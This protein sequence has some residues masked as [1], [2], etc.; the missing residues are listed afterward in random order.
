MKE[1]KVIQ[2]KKEKPK[3]QDFKKDK[4]LPRKKSEFVQVKKKQEEEFLASFRFLK[5]LHEIT[6]NIYHIGQFLNFMGQAVIVL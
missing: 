4:K 2:S 1:K 3:S 6:K 5:T